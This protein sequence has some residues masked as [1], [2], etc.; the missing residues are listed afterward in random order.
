MKITIDTKEDSHH[1]IKKV[2]SMLNHLINN[3][4]TPTYS[5]QPT[6]LFENP[7]SFGQTE[8]TSESTPE[9]PKTPPASSTGIFNMFNSDTPPVSN[10]PEES[11]EQPEEV[12]E[13]KEKSVSIDIY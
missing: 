2:I 13:E 11:A 7:N 8:Q 1:D 5:N 4:E 9:I 6:N 12:S 10:T 3:S